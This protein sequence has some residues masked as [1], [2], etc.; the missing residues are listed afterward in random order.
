MVIATKKYNGVNPLDYLKS[1]IES[2]RLNRSAP[3][4]IPEW[5]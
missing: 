4:L 5:C 2:F 3:R 1:C